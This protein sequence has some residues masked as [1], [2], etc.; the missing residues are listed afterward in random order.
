MATGTCGRPRRVQGRV[1]EL[2]GSI[3]SRSPSPFGDPD[4]LAGAQAPPPDRP[5]VPVVA[6]VGA[7]PRT[8]SNEEVQDIIQ[9]V[10]EVST[11]AK[12][13]PQ[14]RPLKARFPNVYKGDNHMACYNFCQE[15]EDYFATAGAKGPNCIPFAAFFFRDRTSFR[16]QQH[17]R[18]LDNKSLVPPTWDKFKAFFQ[19][20]LGDSRTFVDSFWR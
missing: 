15:C 10:M 20:S 12:E 5:N 8:Y 18:K 1:S 6:P 17:K 9:T 19:K 16:W 14:E 7:P 13:G 11:I 2:I 4:K 3:A